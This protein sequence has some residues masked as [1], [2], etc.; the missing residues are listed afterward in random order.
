M[1]NFFEGWYFLH[2]SVTTIM[3]IPQV[4]FLLFADDILLFFGQPIE[5][6]R[7]AGEYIIAYLPGMWAYSATEILRRF[8]ASQGVFDLMVKVQVVTLIIHVGVCH[9]FVNI[10]EMNIVGIA[11]AI[12]INHNLTFILWVGWITY[13]KSI[14]KEGW[15]I[16]FNKDSFKYLTEYLKVGIPSM[17][18]IVFEV[19]AFEAL[20]I[21]AGMIS[22][23]VQGATVILMNTVALIFMTIR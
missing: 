2:T 3:F 13:N 5:S 17:L 7:L 21:M 4:I 11:Y 19:W 15:W 12:A 18:M 9:L 6:S 22:S 1:S 20:F 23:D 14:V 8:L 10:L 16:W